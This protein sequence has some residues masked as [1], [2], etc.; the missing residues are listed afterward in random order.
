[1]ILAVVWI[2]VLIAALTVKAL[3]GWHTT[4]SGLALFGALDVIVVMSGPV[5]AG[6][7]GGGAVWIV[8]AAAVIG[9]LS[10]LAT[11]LVMMTCGAFLGAVQFITTAT[12][13]GAECA[14]LVSSAPYALLVGSSLRSGQA[15]G[16]SRGAWRVVEARSR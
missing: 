14:S 4:A 16:W 3:S 8:L 15:R 7:T 5:G 13:Y 11:N 2:G 9:G 10:G 1:M 6:L 12:G